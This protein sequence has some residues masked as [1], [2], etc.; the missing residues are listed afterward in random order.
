M[1]KECSC[2]FLLDTLARFQAN[3]GIYYFFILLNMSV[4]KDHYRSYLQ[5]ICENEPE[6][7]RSEVAEDALESECIKTFF[8]ELL[9]HGCSSGMISKLIYYYDTHKF[10]DKHYN[11]IEEIR[12][13]YEDSLGQPLSIRGD[14]K[15]F[16]SWFAFEQTAYQIWSDMNE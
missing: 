2:G 6:T 16:F 9:H 1:Y 10:Y 4:M 14:L 5:S 11:E 3:T 7:I 15:N 13:E 12:D 8:D